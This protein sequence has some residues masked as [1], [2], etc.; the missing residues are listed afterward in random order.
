MTVSFT[1]PCHRDIF[2]PNNDLATA[3]PLTPSSNKYVLNMCATDA[4]VDTFVF[5]IT[6]PMW[7]M[8]PRPAR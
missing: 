8:V 5:N 1:P 7:V 3:T 6:T 2:E 4:D